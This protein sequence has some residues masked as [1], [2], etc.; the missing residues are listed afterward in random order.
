MR[1][2]L[3][4]TIE[5]AISQSEALF[6]ALDKNS[7]P[8]QGSNRKEFILNESLIREVNRF[9]ELIGTIEEELVFESGLFSLDEYQV[10]IVEE[11][12]EM[13][14]TA[15]ALFKRPELL[16][17]WVMEDQD[18]LTLVVMPK[19]VKEILKERVFA[20]HIP[21]VFSSATL[22]VESSFDYMA[23]SLGIENPLTFSVASPYDYSDQ[24]QAALYPL[25]AG[26]IQ[27]REHWHCWRNHREER[28][29]CFL[30]R[31]NW[32]HSRR[33]SLPT[34]RRLP[35]V[36]CTKVRLKSAI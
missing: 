26:M 17:S 24:M 11:H 15:L 32:L 27:S 35:I 8:V 14:Q 29:S 22:S 18:G 34:R 19:M 36:F 4:M 5:D 1:E 13:I 21:I 9:G 20:Q 7:Q 23:Q 31:K 3:A 25:Q 30:H 2:S 10:K 6:A 12:L 16:I 28:L 33:V